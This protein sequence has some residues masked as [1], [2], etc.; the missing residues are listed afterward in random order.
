MKH[1]AFAVI[2]ALAVACSASSDGDGVEPW[3]DAGPDVD[4][5]SVTDPEPEPEPEP[6]DD[7]APPM[8]PLDELARHWA[9]VFYH[10]SDDSDYEADYIVA[11]NYDGDWRGDNNWDNLHSAGAD[12]RS[13]V[14]YSGIETETHWF[15]LYTDFHARDWDENCQTLGIGPDQCHENDMEGAMVVVEKNGTP[16]G[17]FFMLVTEAHNK[18]DLFT[19]N[20]AVTSAESPRLRTTSVTFENGTHPELYVE[21][22]GHGVCALYYNGSDYCEHPTSTSP[23]AFPGGDGMVFRLGT[24]AQSPA[25]GNDRDV[26]YQLRSLEQHL[27]S[28]RADVC[29]SGCLYDRAASYNGISLG[30]SFDGDSHGDDK[31]KP[32]W[33]WDDPSDGP[34]Y[35]GDFFFRPAHAIATWVNVPGEFSLKYTY[36]PYLAGN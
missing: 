2:G 10:D 5:Q 15:L 13:Y 18:L 4:A 20:T 19:N 14:Y 35:T 1:I 31:A 21:S 30:N 22:K 27:W 29:D 26:R 28:R 36:N 7:A 17:R 32:P 12:Y 23:P 24:S 3:A 34:V 25:N 33:G 8:A 16:Y 6:A 9:P 11:V